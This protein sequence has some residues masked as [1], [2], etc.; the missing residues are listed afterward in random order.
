MVMI[1]SLYKIVM[2]GL[3]LL[4]SSFTNAK[5]KPQISL[6]QSQES[7]WQRQQVIITLEVKTDDPF[8]RLEIDSFQEK[9]LTIVPYKQ[10]R[11]E[12]KEHVL[13]IKKWAVFPFIAGNRML[14]LPEV[15]YRPNGG[16]KQKLALKELSLNVRKLPVYVPPT[17]P[18]GNISLISTWDNSW[19]TSPNNLLE[20]KIQVK[21]EGVAQQTLPP[22]TRQIVN[23]KTLRFLPAKSNQKT[24]FLDQGITNQISYSIPLKATQSGLVDLPIIDVQFFEPVSGKLQKTQLSPPLILSLNKWLQGLITIFALFGLIILFVILFRIFKQILLKLVKR[25]QA[26]K[27]LSEANDYQEIRNALN[28]LSKSYGW[29]NNLSLTEFLSKWQREF[30]DSAEL[31][32]TLNNLK[33]FQFSKEQSLEAQTISQTLMKIIKH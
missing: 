25:R 27:A 18:V 16:R 10:Q 2:L 24:L 26:F 32:Q 20:W 5:E 14:K 4:M 8:S 11:I 12:N 21:G 19:L 15:V 13:L 9:G 30:G 6:T 22:I 33:A 7:V 3:L 17:M 1:K 29:G 31:E 28:Q 23:Q